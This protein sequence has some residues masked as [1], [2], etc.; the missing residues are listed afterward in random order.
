MKSKIPVYGN[1]VGGSNYSDARTVGT[2]HVIRQMTFV[3]LA[4]KLVTVLVFFL[5]GSSQAA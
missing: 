1:G 4:I 2:L 3:G 5:C